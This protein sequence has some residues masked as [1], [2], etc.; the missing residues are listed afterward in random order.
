[1][2]L[3]RHADGGAR[4]VGDVHDVDAGRAKEARRFD[5][6]SIVETRRRIH[7]DR[8]DEVFAALRAR[9]PRPVPQTFRKDAGDFVREARSFRERRRIDAFFP[10][11]RRRLDDDRFGLRRRGAPRHA[12]GG[13]HRADVFGPRAAAAADESD[14]RFEIATGEDAQIFGRRHVDRARIDDARQSGVRL[15]GDERGRLQHLLRHVHD[16]RRAR[17]AV[18]ADDVG[19]VRQEDRG[20]ARGRRPVAKARVVFEAH[21]R[22]DRPGEKFARDFERRLH[23]A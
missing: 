13:G 17:A 5:G 1:M 8:H 12:H 4:P 18:D 22:D 2:T 21:L 15:R 19:A 11:G 6:S 14:A 20:G 9:L 7:L 10:L 23:L 16:D 3:V